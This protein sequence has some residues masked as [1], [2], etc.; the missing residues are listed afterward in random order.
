MDLRF[1]GMDPNTGGEGSPTVWVDE[2]TADLVVQDEEADE[3]LTLGRP[4]GDA[5]L[6]CGG[7]RSAGV[8]RVPAHRPGEPRPDRTVVARVA[9]HRA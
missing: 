9:R 6:L 8:R 7:R 5:R 3:L 1:I 2:E 4:P